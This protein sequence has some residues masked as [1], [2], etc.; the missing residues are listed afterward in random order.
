MKLL[1]G[2]SPKI[3]LVVILVGVGVLVMPGIQPSDPLAATHIDGA[4]RLTV[5]KLAPMEEGAICE[6]PAAPQAMAAPAPVASVPVKPGDRGAGA[7]HRGDTVARGAGGGGSGGANAVRAHRGAG[8]G[9]GGA[10]AGPDD[11]RPVP[12]VQR[13]GGRCPERRGRPAGREPVPGD[14]VRPHDE[15]AADGCVVGA[16]AVYPWASDLPGAQLRRLHRS[17]D[18][19]HLL[20]QQRHRT[21]HD[22]LGPGGARERVPGLEAA[23]ADGVVRPRGR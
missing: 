10:P 19:Q 16:E 3:G 14:G 5:H 22:G 11:P 8:S 7:A 9:G 2:L 4:S 21:A 20:A 1:S 13:G 17:G 6:V 15:H 23:H 12:A 18:G